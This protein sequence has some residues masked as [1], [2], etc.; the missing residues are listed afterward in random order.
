MDRQLFFGKMNSFVVLTDSLLSLL[1][2]FSSGNSYKHSTN[3]SCIAAKEDNTK[4]FQD[5]SICHSRTEA[6]CTHTEWNLV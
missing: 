3:S 2:V 6:R 1:P 4:H 5:N